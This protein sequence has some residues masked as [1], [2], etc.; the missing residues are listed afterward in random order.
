[1]IRAL[2]AAAVLTLPA[3]LP[4]AA[5]AEQA[6]HA[7]HMAP[8][9]AAHG[10][11]DAAAPDARAATKPGQA[12]FAAIQEIVAMLDV[13]PATDWS[14]VDIEA[15][16]RHLADM[17]NVTL[18]AEAAAEPVE[19]GMRYTVTGTGPVRDSIRRMVTAHAATMSGAGGMT[20]TAEEHPEGAAMTVTVDDLAAL[21]RLK[22]LGFIG[23]MALGMHHQRHH[24]MI[25]RGRT[26]HE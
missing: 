3:S 5:A 26:P 21:P 20:I 8:P 10:A 22:A 4:P 15:L 6:G 18:R 7:E 13:D 23:V 12:A 24:L 14:T 17:D 2:L 16:R 1:M 25:A 11:H 9:E 19:G